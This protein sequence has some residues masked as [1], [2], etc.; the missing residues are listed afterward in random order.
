MS[1]DT[2]HQPAIGRQLRVTI[3]HEWLVT[4]AG[5]E[6]VVAELLEAFPGANLLT[7][8]IAPDRVPPALAAAQPSFLQHLP[9]AVDHHTWLLP[10]LPIAWH[11][12]RPVRDVD[13]V[14][15]SS[16]SCAK[17]V[18]VADGIP[19]V[20]YCHTPMRYAW[21]FDAE[22]HRLPRPLQPVAAPLMG[23]FRR[24]DVATARGV[25]RFVANSAAVADR[26]R[27]FYRREAD[28]VHPPVRTDFFTPAIED[29]EGFLYVGRLVS[30]KRPDLVIEAFR[31]LPHQLT[32]V[33]T[34]AQLAKLRDQAPANVRFVPEASDDEL[35]RLYRS[36][37]AL[38]FPGVEDFG[39]VMAEAQACGT[40]VIAAAEGGA[41]DIVHPGLT[42][43][44]VA[45]PDVDGLRAAVREAA[46][47]TLDSEAIAASADRFSVDRFR[48]EMRLIVDAV[49]QPD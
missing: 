48:R 49:V 25:T 30:Y 45:R 21:Y 43:W 19:H 18:R 23:A 11:A 46:A 3:A 22:R 6:R 40:P 2:F 31:G 10:L 42:G 35:R 38:V 9:G 5:S 44:L 33:G 14:I 8:L 4:Y 41:L 20:C 27:R 15:S 7:T 34:G 29:R 26:I 16:H 39:I 13:V 32:V 36:S 47:T 1:E 17:A 28:V 37:I 12:R 24:W